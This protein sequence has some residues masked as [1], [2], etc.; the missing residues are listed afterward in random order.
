[1]GINHHQNAD[2][3]QINLAALEED[4]HI[5]E[6]SNSKT[7]WLAHVH[8]CDRIVSC[9]GGVCVRLGEAKPPKKLS[10]A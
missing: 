3:T 1:L 4:M 2:D 9:M 6:A 7:A 8:A 5:V 10:K